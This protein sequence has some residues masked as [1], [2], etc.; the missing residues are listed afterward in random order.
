MGMKDGE[1]RSPQAAMGLLAGLLALEKIKNPTDEKKI[2]L[3]YSEYQKMLEAIQ[4][5]EEAKQVIYAE[6]QREIEQKIGVSIDEIMRWLF[7]SNTPSLLGYIYHEMDIATKE[8]Q[9]S[10]NRIYE[11]Y[12]ELQNTLE[13]INKRKWWQIWKRKNLR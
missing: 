13:Q 5:K 10:Y 2:I 8:L 6:C 7:D 3:P 9:K 4:K 11:E 1:H 12:K